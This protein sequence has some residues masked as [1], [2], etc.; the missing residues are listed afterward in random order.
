M[1]KMIQHVGWKLL[2][3]FQIYIEVLE[4]SDFSQIYY[5]KK[6]CYDSLRI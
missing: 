6:V 2:S 5:P 1:D 3:W 4:F